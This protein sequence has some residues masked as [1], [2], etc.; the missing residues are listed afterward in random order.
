MK[1]LLV[2]LLVVG[3]GTV[4]VPDPNK[5]E[6]APDTS[7]SGQKLPKQDT[8]LPG[9]PG[10]STE[11]SS[12][13]APVEETPLE[14]VILGKRVGTGKT[15]TSLG[16]AVYVPS[17]EHEP[18]CNSQNYGKLFYVAVET[19]FMYCSKENGMSYVKMPSGADDLP[20][21]YY[22]ETVQTWYLTRDATVDECKYGGTVVEHWTDS[23]KNEKL[24]LKV[25]RSY[26]YSTSC[27]SR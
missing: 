12:E 23:N 24:D 26:T 6:T 18:T 11:T 3:C 1:V 21:Q 15:L 14:G 25:D 20:P 13:E 19:V 16:S 10:K 5:A 9:S 2:S 4:V 27:L 22:E 17:T 7:K 8:G